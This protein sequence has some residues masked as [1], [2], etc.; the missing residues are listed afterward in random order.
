[1]TRLLQSLSTLRAYISVDYA[2][3]ASDGWLVL[4]GQGLFLPGYLKVFHFNLIPTLWA[5]HGATKHFPAL[6]DSFNELT[7]DRKRVEYSMAEIVTGALFMF[8]LK[9]KSRNAY[10]NDRRDAIFVKNYPRL[11]I[12]ILADGLYPNS[13]VFDI[14]RK[15][16]WEF[17]INLKDGCLKSVRTE[18]ALL[19]VT[20]IEEVVY[21]ANKTENIHLK[22]KF[23]NEIEYSGHNYSWIS[24]TQTITR[25][26]DKEVETKKFVYITS[27]NQS[28]KTVFSTADGVR[29]RWKIENEGFNTQKNSDYE[30]E[31]KY[32][33]VSYPAMQNYY[34][35]LQLAHMINQFVE[36][37]AD[38][39]ELL[40]E[41]SKQ[42]LVDLWKALGTFMHSIPHTAEQ[43]AAFLSS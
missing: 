23:L 15:N 37:S 34:Q 24:C 21:R 30:L 4:V 35:M 20:S 9:E 14:C 12:C 39:V 40:K 13:T 1:M 42:T 5:W 33:R 18:V 22:F 25:L 41:H 36:K 3:L 31:H 10:N 6:F 7:D 17:I 11:P 19:G 2:R 32:S 16:K 38:I 27:I 26:S 29:L 43:V 28:L 8:L